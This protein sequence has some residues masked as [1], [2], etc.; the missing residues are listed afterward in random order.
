[1]VEK[2]K[3]TGLRKINLKDGEQ[4]Q[5]S[6]QLDEIQLAGGSTSNEE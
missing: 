3:T 1:M 5:D 2:R 6:N 4:V